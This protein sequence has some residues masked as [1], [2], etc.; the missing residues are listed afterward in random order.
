MNKKDRG[1]ISKIAVRASK[2]T[3]ENYPIVTACM[4]LA[5]CHET[6]SL[7][8]EKLMAFDDNNFL[9]DVLG[10]NRHLDHKTGELK[11]CF[12]PRCGG[13]E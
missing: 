6:N 11:D 5:A 3:N 10:I 8:L 4:D 2:L 7:N 13:Q 9:H 12:W 1:L